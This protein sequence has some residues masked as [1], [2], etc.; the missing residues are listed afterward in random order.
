MSSNEL[1]ISVSNLCKAYN[2]YN[3]PRDFIVETITSK[4][5]HIK[6]LALRDVSFEIRRGEIVGIIGSN[7]A[8][9]STL[10]KILAG[11]LDRTSGQV[12]V[13]GKISAILELGTGFHPD[14]TGRE[15]IIIGGM[16][17]GMTREEAIRKAPSIIEFSELESVIDQP[18]KT[19][20]SGMQARLTFSTAISIDPDILIIDEALAAGDAY[21]VRKSLARL[22]EICRSGVTVLLVTHSTDI[23]ATLCQRAIWLGDGTIRMEGPAKSVANAYELDVERRITA[24]YKDAQARTFASK[25]SA[26]GEAYSF[27]RAGIDIVQ[28][29][30]EDSNGQER[31]SF[32]QGEPLRIVIRWRG[33]FDGTLHPVIGIRSTSGVV[34]GFVGCEHG[35][36]LRTPSGEG[37]IALDIIDPLYG[38]GEYSISLSLVRSDPVQALEE[39]VCF[40]RNAAK[41][42]VRRRFP[43]SYC[44]AYE[45]RVRWRDSDGCEI[46][47]LEIEA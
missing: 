20:S 2:V 6:Q 14:F 44:Y 13:Y 10:L 33:Q 5:R 22:R 36:Y 24:G 11:T 40:I 41:F 42:Y 19:Y 25:V 17:L 43:R 1:A 15:N 29:R 32:A 28:C 39:E 12:A 16:C 7:G 26:D 34:S 31:E 35:V 4:P 45:P 30:V 47:S 23:I 21:F 18:F 8:G 38:L 37:L 9:K 27:L 3:S 46:S